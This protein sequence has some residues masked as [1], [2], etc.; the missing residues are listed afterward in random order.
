MVSGQVPAKMA[1]HVSYSLNSS[2]GVILDR[3]LYGDYYEGY[4]GGC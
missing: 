1:I 2:K 3:G 4:Q